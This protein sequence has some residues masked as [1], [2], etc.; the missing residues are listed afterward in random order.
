MIYFNIKAYDILHN[1]NS[2]K[3]DKKRHLFSPWAVAL[4][5]EEPEPW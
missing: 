4:S 1:C 3:N 2:R 5:R